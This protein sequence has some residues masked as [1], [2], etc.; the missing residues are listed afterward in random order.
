MPARATAAAPARG[1]QA[2]GLEVRLLFP[3]AGITGILTVLSFPR[4]GIDPL[5]WIAFAPL[6]AAAAGAGPRRGFLAGWLAGLAIECGGFSWVLY[7]MRQFTGL[8][9]AA[10]LLFLPWLLYET[11]PWGILGLVLGSLRRRGAPL[12]GGWAFLAVPAG[13]AIE[14][15]FPR[16]FPW[17]IAVALHDRA[18]LIQAA[19]LL[20]AGGLTALI[21]AVNVVVALALRRALGLGP[22]PARSLA[23]AALLLASANGYGWLRLRQVDAAL[24]AAPVLQVGM[25]QPVAP[26][27]EKA[28]GNT[29]FFEKMKALTRAIEAKCKLDLVL[30]PEGSDTV[31]FVFQDGRMGRPQVDREKPTGFEDLDE[32]LAAGTGSEVIGG[33]PGTPPSSSFRG[34]GRRRGSTTRTCC[35]SSASTCR[36][37]KTSP[38]RCAGSSP[39]IGSMA[40]G[41]DCPLFELPSPKG[42]PFRFRVL[43]CYEG[44]LPGYLR[45]AAA[46]ASFLVNLTEDIWYGRTSH[47][48]QHLSVLQLRAV[49]ER[50]SIARCANAGPSGVIDPAGRMDPRTV[51]FR[52][53]ERAFPLRPVRLWSLY[54][55][56]GW[57][58]PWA[59]LLA[60]AGGLA[61]ARAPR[62][63]RGRSQ[64]VLSGLKRPV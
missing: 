32:P 43:L 14:A 62:E 15:F 40:A 47:V 51:P 61:V 6:I 42:G 36:S 29:L 27:E 44:I 16:L 24:A 4:F 45:A 20:G 63:A 64:K 60:A 50:I 55:A 30:W 21:L 59:C 37:G 49:E 22:F 3:A 13:V 1:F 46:G 10:A 31:G 57:L 41:T 17:Q 38:G 7:A 58:F 11:L 34:S 53:E 9:P 26:P 8:G 35:S 25:V 23:A 18:W 12:P 19:D 48:G 5:V 2:A 33:S 28:P 56:G 54:D 52:E 39:D